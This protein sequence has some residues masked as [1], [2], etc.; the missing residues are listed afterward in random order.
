MAVEVR[1]GIFIENLSYFLIIIFLLKKLT[2][3]LAYRK[4]YVARTNQIV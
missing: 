1:R 4:W 3:M 2:S